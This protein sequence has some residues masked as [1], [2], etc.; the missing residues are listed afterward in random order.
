M[1]NAT[2]L[3]TWGLAQ[4]DSH[5]SEV[6][7]E[8]AVHPLSGNGLVLAVEGGYLDGIISWQTL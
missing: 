8:L 1:C 3:R 2:D 4:L 7:D 6:V 5:L